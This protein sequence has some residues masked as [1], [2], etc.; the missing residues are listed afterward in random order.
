MGDVASSDSMCDSSTPEPVMHRC[1]GCGRGV[2]CL[3]ECGCFTCKRLGPIP[4]APW[5]VEHRRH[6]V[7][8]IARFSPSKLRRFRP[9]QARRWVCSGVDGKG[10][11]GGDSFHDVPLVGGAESAIPV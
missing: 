5:C 8:V 4:G 2:P 11:E 10:V 3:V 6:A 9:E 1:V 7:P